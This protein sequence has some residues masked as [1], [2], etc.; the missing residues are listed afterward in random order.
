MALYEQKLS[1]HVQ[2]ARTNHTL[3]LWV[4]SKCT[5]VRTRE[6]A[7]VQGMYLHVQIVRASVQLYVQEKQH[8]CK[9]CICT[10]KSYEQEGF[11][12]EKKHYLRFLR[13]KAKEKDDS[14][15]LTYS[16]KK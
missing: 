6:T 8:T 12:R 5:I 14:S 15:N 1:S 4:H 16:E 9:E 7:H 3:K 10:Y 2:V 13:G 11:H